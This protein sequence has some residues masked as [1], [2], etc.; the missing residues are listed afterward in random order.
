MS[1][2]L[3]TIGAA[4]AGAV[5][6][7]TRSDLSGQPC[8]NCGEPVEARFCPNCGQLAASFHRP[9]WTLLGET[10]SDMFALDGRLARTLPTLMFRPGVLTREYISGKRARYVPPFRMFLLA[11]LLFYLVLF[12]TLGNQGWLN[13]VINIDENTFE[14]SELTDEQREKLARVID[15]ET[16]HVDRAAAAE[17]LAEVQV[18][19]GEPE[20]V[21]ERVSRVIENPQLFQAELEKWAPRMSVLMVPLTIVALVILHFWRRDLFVYD[22]AI[23][24]LHL[25]S[26]IYL[27]GAG[28]MLLAPMVGGGIYGWLGLVIVIYVWLSLR[29]AARAGWILATLRLFILLIFWII[30]VFALVLGA[31][32]VSG[33]AISE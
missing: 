7:T 28:A 15:S 27:A 25:H 3:E 14:S 33:L 20:Q 2:E 23:H 26:W 17:I 11:S 6:R 21:V 13:G 9:V 5:S 18:D 22:H 1:G 30:V 12:A 31:I 19:N 4:A 16:G 29:T 24:A 8:R 32:I 10:L